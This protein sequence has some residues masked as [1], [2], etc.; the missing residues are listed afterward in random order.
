MIVE[1]VHAPSAADLDTRTAFVEDYVRAIQPLDFVETV[2][3][4]LSGELTIYTI[5]DADLDEIDHLLYDIYGSVIDRYP[6]V[7]VNFRLIH[8][9]DLAY[10]PIPETGQQAYWRA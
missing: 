7:P 2:S 5:Y 1:P 10:S 4:D 8:R 6:D 3:A 9:S